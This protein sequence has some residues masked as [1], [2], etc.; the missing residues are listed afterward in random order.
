MKRKGTGKKKNEPRKSEPARRS[1]RPDKDKAFQVINFR[2]AKGTVP[3]FTDALRRRIGTVPEAPDK[4]KAFQV[5]DFSEV[6]FDQPHPD[7]GVAKILIANASWVNT[8]EGTVVTLDATDY[9]LAGNGMRLQRLPSGTHPASGWYGTVEITYTPLDLNRRNRALVQLVELDLA[10]RPG[11]ST[12][13]IGG[14][15]SRSQRNYDEER[16]RII[17]SARSRDIA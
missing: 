15:Y 11:A 13:Q 12:E 4:D 17:A 8:T 5:I 1:R 14:D 3:G 16:A 10:F 9:A 6:G 2:D 7:V